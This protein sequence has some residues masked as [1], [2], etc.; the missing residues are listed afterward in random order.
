MTVF[1]EVRDLSVRLGRAD[2]VR[3]VSFSIE[4]GEWLGL[5]GPN[6]AGKT[7]IMRALAGMVPFRGSIAIDDCPIAA[8]SPRDIAR[9]VALVP[10]RPFAPSEL[11]VSEYV[12]LGRTPHIA[13]FATER[14]SDVRA[15]ER[16]LA[17]MSLLSFADRPLG[18][19][20]GGELQRAVLARA[21]AQEAA[22]LLMDEPT[23]ALDL[24]HQQL[25]LEMVDAIRR[26]QGLTVISAMHDLSLAGHF[27]DRLLLVD[28]GL[29]VAE[30][31]PPEVLS[32][33]NIAM[34]YGARARVLRGPDGV[35]VLPQRRG[36][37]R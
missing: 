14:A 3:D 31:S 10:Q 2:V 9:R 18:T 7:T 4:R 1:V 19:L 24:G 17:S 20:S 22:V 33:R 8:S 28:R 12:L 11:T 35:F 5:I 13:Y 29:I 16:A 34:Y 37:P 25:A 15:A 26:E 21:L 30:G 36:G 32:E 6:G 27:G 23:A